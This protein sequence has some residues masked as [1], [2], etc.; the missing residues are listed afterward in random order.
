ML[1]AA[2][3]ADFES[4][5]ATGICSILYFGMG[6]FPSI[7]NKGEFFKF[8]FFDQILACPFH[9]KQRS[10]QNIIFVNFFY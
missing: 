8:N 6:N 5:F 3:E 4:P 1:A 9:S 10:L 2:I 7:N